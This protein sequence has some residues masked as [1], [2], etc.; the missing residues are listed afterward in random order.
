MEVQFSFGL[1]SD[2]QYCD[3]DAWRERYF[4]E[5]PA[6]LREAVEAFNGRDLAFVLHLGD[7]ID[8][9]DASFGGILPVFAEINAPLYHIPGNHDFE[10]VKRYSEEEV[11]KLMNI[12]NPGYRSFSLGKWRF[13][14]LNGTEISTFSLNPTNR[15]HGEK[16]L[17]LLEKAK[18]LQA[19]PW[20]AGIGVEQ[21]IWLQKEIEAAAHRNE[22]VIIGCHYPIYP[23]NDHN[24]WN[25]SEILS[26]ISQY[27]HVKLWL[28]G[29]QHSGNYGIYHHVHCLTMVGMVEKHETAY[30]IAHVYDS[31]IE[32]EGFG[33]EEEIR[34]LGF[35]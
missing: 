17:Q 26:L 31:R 12:P 23:A 18:L 6:K 11:F 35:K 15:V 4:R 13:I 27:S 7:V 33:R 19:K 2:V 3:G 25:D 21:F 30:A 29:R 16:L 34:I 22:T 20:N 9:W 24:L 14:L 10:A 5:S 1:I 8:K 32:I 28:N